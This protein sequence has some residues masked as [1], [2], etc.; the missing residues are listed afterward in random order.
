M[1]LMYY[2]VI[3]HDTLLRH[4]D[5]TDHYFV[6]LAITYFLESISV[7]GNFYDAY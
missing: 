6:L 5:T 2:D 1:F 3:H 7:T 4:V